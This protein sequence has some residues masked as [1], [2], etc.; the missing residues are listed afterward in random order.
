METAADNPQDER[1]R[2]TPREEGENKERVSLLL[3][4]ASE[5]EKLRQ[6][7]SVVRRRGRR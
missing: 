1:R 6:L 7:S 5:R 4:A 2:R 3:R